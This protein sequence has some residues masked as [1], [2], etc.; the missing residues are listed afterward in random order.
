MEVR[1]KIKNNYFLL[2]GFKHDA[3]RA[4]FFFKFSNIMLR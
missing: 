1:L 3:E 2:K 4:I